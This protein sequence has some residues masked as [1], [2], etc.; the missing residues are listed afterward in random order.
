[1][2]FLDAHKNVDDDDDDDVSLV[3]GKGNV[4]RKKFT[5]N[6]LY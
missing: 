4:F 2:G 1:M 5:P 6:L 3:A